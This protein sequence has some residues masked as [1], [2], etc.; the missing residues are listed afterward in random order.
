MI[1]LRLLATLSLCAAL[2]WP[3][4]SSKTKTGLPGATPVKKAIA[5]ANSGGM[6]SPYAEFRYKLA[7]AFCPTATGEDKASMAC[8][9]F[10]LTKKLK[11]ATDPEEKKRLLGVKKKLLGA[12][13]QQ[14]ATDEEKKKTMMMARARYTKF[15]AA[16]CTGDRATSDDACTNTLMKKLYGPKARK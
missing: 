10:A 14:T 8:Q 6:P 15:Y 12:M 16:Y 2:S 7:S 4:S 11:E 1:V 9:S 13:Q 5:S 3:G